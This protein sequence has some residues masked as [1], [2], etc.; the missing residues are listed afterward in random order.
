MRQ[1]RTINEVLYHILWLADVRGGVDN[2]HPIYAFDDLDNL[3]EWVKSQE[4]PWTDDSGTP[5]FYGNIHSY[6][7]TYRKGS[8]LEWYNPPSSLESKDCYGGVTQEW[9]DE[10]DQLTIPVNPSI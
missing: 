9:I 10:S 5:D 1:T 2:A 6:G 3:K 8:S 7:K 4:E